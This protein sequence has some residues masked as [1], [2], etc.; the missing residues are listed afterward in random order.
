MK[1]L[2]PARLQVGDLVQVISPSRSLAIISDEVRKVATETLNGLGLEVSFGKYAFLKDE[3]NSSPIEAR[4]EDIHNAF[5]NPDVKAILTTI[6]GFNCNQLL[7]YLDFDLIKAN[8]KILCGY[9][10]ITILLNAI[11]HKTGMVTYYGPHFSTFGVKKGNEFTVREFE[12]VMFHPGPHTVN[13][14]AQWSD[15]EWYLDQE[16]RSFFTNPGAVAIHFGEARGTLIGGNLDTFNLLQ[17]T[18]HFPCP[19]SAVLL[20]EEDDFAGNDFAVE[21]DRNLESI[22]QQSSLKNIAGIL[23]GRL[24]KRV[25]YSI[26]Q[27]KKTI[28]SKPALKDI[29]VVCG[30]DFGHTLPMTPFA[31]G[32]ELSMSVT[33]NKI[34]LSA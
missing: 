30:L 19:E 9:S 2:F 6:G 18:D 12:K 34:E 23:F 1:P 25:D 26:E 16:N 13:S 28:R 29:P 33:E 10:D 17:G 32:A 14:S 3:Y 15:D 8:P 22:L 24:P 20:V 5:R 31:I 7:P 21:I 11:Y 27:L 4:V